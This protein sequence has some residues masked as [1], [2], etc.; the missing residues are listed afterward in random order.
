MINSQLKL[1]ALIAILIAILFCAWAKPLDIIATQ[2]VD[3]G[4]KRAA[5]SFGTARLIGAGIAVVNSIDVG[6]G[7][8]FSP[9]QLLHPLGELVGQFAELML[10]ATIVFG[11]MKVLLV[12]GGSTSVSLG[13]TA[14]TPVWLWYRWRG[15]S[16]P[17]G[18]SKLLVVAMLVRFAVPMVMVGSDAVYK[19]FMADEYNSN[20]AIIAKTADQIDS[21]P[22]SSFA[23]VTSRINSLVEKITHISDY[24]I[25]LIVVFLLQT[26]VLPLFFFWALYRVLMAMFQNSA[27]G[28]TNNAETVATLDT[29]DHSSLKDQALEPK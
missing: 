21:S 14:I 19:A 18:L 26:L 8:K 23:N 7:V 29:Y 5:I 27:D 16:P 3:E 25:R 20:Q 2:R 1:V 11:T 12:I 13:V 24:L 15:E 6:I 28:R 10:A 17:S 9:G 22:V 4:F